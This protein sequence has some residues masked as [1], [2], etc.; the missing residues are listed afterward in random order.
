M[1][2]P[3]QHY[4]L[5]DIHGCYAELLRLEKR[6]SRLCRRHNT[7]PHFISCG[8]LVDR[9]PDSAKVLDHFWRG[10]LRGTHT[11]VLGNH[12]IMMLEVVQAYRPDLFKEITLPPWFITVK[13]AYEREDTSALDQSFSEYREGSKLSWIQQGG[14]ETLQSFG[15]DEKNPKTWNFRPQ[16]LSYLFQSRFVHRVENI[17]VTHAL[18]TKEAL[19]QYEALEKIT[20]KENEFEWELCQLAIDTLIWNRLPVTDD[21]PANEVW[22]SGHTPAPK[23]RRLAGNKLLQID[24]GCSIDGHLTAWCIETN[25]FYRTR[26]T[27]Q[28]L[29]DKAL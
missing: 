28:N 15:F 1:D 10:S 26:Q 25:R 21:V 19:E 8:D 6:I 3:R 2:S 9:G 16:L 20:P 29:A 5:G 7:T 18:P 27:S 14:H 12:E 13:A 4:V 11:L 23:I 24:T 17:V 22:V